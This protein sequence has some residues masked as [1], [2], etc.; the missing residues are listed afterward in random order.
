MPPDTWFPSSATL[1]PHFPRSAMYSTDRRQGS[2]R[3]SA[4]RLPS[5]TALLEER[6]CES[7][8]TQRQTRIFLPGRDDKR[9][10]R[11]NDNGIRSC[12]TTTTAISSARTTTDNSYYCDYFNDD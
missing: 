8:A 11:V 4:K 12:V 1:K 6:P 9:G 7:T 10:R 5:E 2:M 3:T